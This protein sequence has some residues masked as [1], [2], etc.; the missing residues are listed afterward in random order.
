MIQ[1][2]ILQYLTEAINALQD[3]LLPRVKTIVYPNEYV[4]IEIS[5]QDLFFEVFCGGI[6]PQY[7]T[8]KSILTSVIGTIVINGKTNTG[9]S[10]LEAISEALIYN[11]LP[12]NPLK[13]H[14]FRIR[15]SCNKCITD[16]YIS[17]VERSETGIDEGRC[18]VSIF[19]TFDIHEG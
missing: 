13:K 1:R 2:L 6:A 19:I 3:P 11:F 9:S 16:V 5:E 7:E 4:P 14:G 17:A 18:K 10:F 12:T 15:D 8:E